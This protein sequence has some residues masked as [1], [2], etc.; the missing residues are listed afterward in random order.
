MNKK[1]TERPIHKNRIGRVQKQLK[2]LV[3]RSSIRAIAKNSGVSA[4]TI[5]NYL[6]GEG[7]RTLENLDA[8][9]TSCGEKLGLLIGEGSPGAQ[10]IDRKLLADI[11]A[12]IE[13]ALEEEAG[14]RLQ[15][16]KK[17]TL[18]F[19]LYDIFKESGKEP[20]TATILPFLKMGT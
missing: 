9:A 1:G 19:A 20:N 13:Q 2:I 14:F 8:I 4:G 16:S 15:P 5:H 18:A 3:D 7:L 10:E 11:L 17:V 12:G 6:N